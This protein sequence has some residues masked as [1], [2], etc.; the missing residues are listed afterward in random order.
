MNKFHFYIPIIIFFSLVNLCN[1]VFAQ[2]KTFT[3]SQ[4]T[5]IPDIY[6]KSISVNIIDLP[7]I[8]AL[9]SIAEM[10]GFKINYNENVI[11]VDKTVSTKMTN[12]PAIEILS[13]LLHQNK[14]DF[15]FSHGEQL[16]IIKQL[17][18]NRNRAKL[19]FTLD[20][21]VADAKT[22]EILIG[23]NIFIKNLSKH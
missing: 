3:D 8:D 2:E 17:P 5:N 16:V 7:L 1:S 10:G 13:F 14:L 11:P 19:T 15:V 6:L 20:G 4:G 22:G 12:K 21:F 23:T 9:H 18:G